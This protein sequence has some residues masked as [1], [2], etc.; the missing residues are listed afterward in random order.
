M[1]NYGYNYPRYSENV[2]KMQKKTME[3]KKEEARIKAN[4]HDVFKKA[5]SGF[6]KKS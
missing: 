2:V 4:M 5:F 6:K 1:K 3:R